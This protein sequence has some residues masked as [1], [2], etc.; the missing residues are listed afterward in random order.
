MLPTIGS[1]TVP[2]VHSDMP[3]ALA[4]RIAQ[5]GNAMLG[6]RKHVTVLFADVRGSTAL[7]DQLDPEH[8]LEL[9]GPV[10][11]VLMDAVHQH[12]GFV[13]QT[14]GDGIMALF[15]AP[16]ANEDHA[17]RACE[18]AMAMRAGVGALFPESPPESGRAVAIRIGINSGEVVIHSIGRNLTMNY[19]AVGKSVHLAARMEELAAPGKIMLTSAT[20]ELAKGFIEATP[21]GAVTVRGVSEPVETFELIGTPA[22][23]RW[24]VRSA[25]GLS[26][27]AG[28]QAE[29]RTLR[30]AF[31]STAAGK[32]RLVTIVG[33]P[34]IGKS[35]L[36]HEFVNTAAAGWTILE[37]ACA[38]QHMNSSYYPISRLIRTLFNIGIDDSPEIAARRVQEGV[39]RFYRA[40]APSIPAILSMLDL[41][42]DDGDWDNLTPP[43]RR[44]QVIEAIKALIFHVKRTS[45]V[46]I[47]IED[48]HW[49]DAETKL[50]LENIAGLLGDTR[51]LLMATQR[52]E[53]T[54][55]AERA[56]LRVDLFP[57]K[58][59][60]SHAMVDWLMGD[61]ISL[62]PVKR[63]ILAQAQG[64]PL[65][66]EELIQALK[67]SGA[68]EGEPRHYRLTH[69]TQRID[70][71]ETIH[72]VLATR[73]D[74]LDARSKSLLQTCAVIGKDAPA[75]LLSKMMDTD[76]EELARQLRTL[77]S[78]D[79]LYK[80][81]GTG[82][83]EYSFKHDLTRDVAYGTLLLGMRRILHAKAVEIIESNFGNRLDEHIDRLADH[84][85]Y[86]EL[87][88]KA[89]P[90]QLRS[91][92][93]AVKRGAN[94][95]AVSIFERG[96]ETLSHLAAS[97]AKTKAEIDF[98]LAVILALE[99][100]GRHRRIVDVLLDARRFAEDSDDP[101]RTAAVNC[102]LAVALWRLGDNDGAMAA[103][104]AAKSIAEGVGGHALKFAALHNLG[105]VH[106]GT[107]SFAK[108]VE[109]HRAC[110]ALESPDLDDKR[111]GW[112]GLPSVVLRTF[113]ADALLELG[114]IEEAEAVAEE[115][116][117]RADAADHAYSRC[118]INQ[119]RS[120]IRVAQGRPAEAILL[121]QDAWQAS[122][123]LELIQMYPIIAARWGEAYL[124]AG[125]FPAA[126]DIV[127]M[128]EKLDI[129]LAQN[130]FGWGQLFVAQGHALLAVGRQ[131]DARAAAE[132]AMRLAEQ[133]GERPQQ[134]YA[135]KLLGD[136]SAAEQ[137]PAE[138]EGHFRRA[139]DLAEECGMNPLKQDCVA[140]LA[141]VA[142][143]RRTSDLALH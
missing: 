32:G 21:L 80:V 139:I 120:R 94:Q 85:F 33:A 2:F 138:A 71:P 102:H 7:I 137:D 1:P 132:R 135:L 46:L 141:A 133:R 143:A 47:L 25:R 37:T 67:D 68:I 110:L 105:I 20:Y 109:M 45:P 5:S 117:R 62:N 48:L 63:R 56:H 118:Q 6:E 87:W 70:M 140:A 14:R 121:L 12:D 122:I 41:R 124:A 84:A 30:S 65:F 29:L 34:G 26:A 24:Q 27:I 23:T 66:I 51:I 60:D 125:D 10:M 39:G 22:R 90:Y 50:I 114:E 126:L 129:P 88:E 40:L 44:N 81:G 79:L 38:S 75:A 82:A 111:A 11:K 28:R 92:R 49:A 43:Q 36:V 76:P 108:S 9:L 86:A 64:N 19:D 15:G 99:P 73:V 59:Q 142:G 119:V 115:G 77:E 97:E 96:I 55:S 69:S 8:A 42:S 35:R 31:E 3:A 61:D 83:P 53:S 134:A 136:I 106:H 91:C 72:S 13:N 113:L 89:V 78:A 57:L 17:L 74:L 101:R 95:D 112:A 128:P 93:R 4:E 127:S 116:G 98:R 100:L 52:P 58:E 103:A 130:T 18:A 107:G 131:G 16:L 123:D 104:E 54:W